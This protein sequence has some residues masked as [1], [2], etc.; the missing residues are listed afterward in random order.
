MLRFVNWNKL[1][2]VQMKLIEMLILQ[3]YTRYSQ[4]KVLEKLKFWPDDGMR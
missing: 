2:K 4:T 1:K 3:V